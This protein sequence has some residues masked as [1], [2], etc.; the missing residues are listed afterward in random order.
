MC[1]VNHDVSAP[2]L[3]HEDGPIDRKMVEHSDHVVAHG[4]EVVARVGFVAQ[5]V[6]PQVDGDAR[7]TGFLQRITDSVPH[8]CVRRQAMDQQEDRRIRATFTSLN[9]SQGVTVA[10]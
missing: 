1:R 6:S 7:I 8:A 9:G 5:A 4:V 10:G 2:G 3:P